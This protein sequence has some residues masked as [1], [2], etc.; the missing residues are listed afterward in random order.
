MCRDSLHGILR[1][2][3]GSAGLGLIQKR[4]GTESMKK[5]GLFKNL[6]LPADQCL[7]K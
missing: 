3:T 5:G 2:G 4:K 1:T 7:Q 6:V